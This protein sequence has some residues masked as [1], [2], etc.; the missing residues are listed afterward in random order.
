MKAFSKKRFSLIEEQLQPLE[1][2]KIALE[3]KLNEIDEEVSQEQQKIV[4]PQAIVRNFKYFKMVF[5]HLAFEKQRDLLHLLIK[6]IVY[7]KEPSKLKIQFYNLP[8]IKKPPTKPSK[9]NAG[10]SSLSS[11]FDERMYWLPDQHPKTS[12]F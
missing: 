5:T 11:R 9:G 1:D 4:D 3:K 8:E 6:K 10:G 12:V 2:Q 7:N